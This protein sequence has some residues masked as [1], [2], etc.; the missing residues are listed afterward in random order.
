MHWHWELGIFNNFIVILYWSQYEIF[1][2]VI[3]L[4]AFCLEVWRFYNLLLYQE[5]SLI[6]IFLCFTASAPEDGKYQCL[7][8]WYIVFIYL[9]LK[10]PIFG[11]RLT[12][13]GCNQ[14]E[15]RTFSVSSSC[16]P[17]Q[18]AAVTSVLNF[19][20]FLLQTL[21]ISFFPFCYRENRSSDE[22]PEW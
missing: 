3:Y 1:E 18:A 5:V 11:K 22:T 16:C 4:K 19:T 12:S 8:F 20:R 6:F 14:S 21:F 13:W 10:S 9:F 2:W 7:Q 17:L 15:K